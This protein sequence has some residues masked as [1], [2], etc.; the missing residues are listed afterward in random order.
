VLPLPTCG[1]QRLARNQS[2]LLELH[3]SAI[4]GRKENRKLDGDADR[5]FKIQF[6]ATGDAALN[7][8]PNVIV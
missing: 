7:I 4:S 8:A 2:S 3:E 5:S 1:K 6:M